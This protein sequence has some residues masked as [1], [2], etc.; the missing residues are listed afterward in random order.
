LNPIIKESIESISFNSVID[1]GC[2]NGHASE[3]FK[4]KGYFGVDIS[5]EAIKTASS[6]YPHLIF[7][8]ISVNPIYWNLKKVDLIYCYTTLIHI[9]EK[10]FSTSLT[11]ILKC[12]K[13]AIFI[14]FD[15]SIN[16]VNYNFVP[17]CNE[18]NFN[19]ILKPYKKIRING[20]N[21]S[22]FFVKGNL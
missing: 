17:W 9:Q 20:T 11:K 13:E 19:E 22:V 3:M 1:F 7:K 21:L 4:G 12:C 10:Y 18:R 5:T 6:K 15:L 14:E 8:T 16:K 2:S